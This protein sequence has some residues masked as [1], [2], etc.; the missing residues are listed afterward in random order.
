MSLTKRI[1]IEG[2]PAYAAVREQVA[3]QGRAHAAQF[4]VR[5]PTRRANRLP[6]RRWDPFWPSALQRAI[7]TLGHDSVWINDG[8]FVQTEEEREAVVER[9]SEIADAD[10]SR[11]RAAITRTGGSA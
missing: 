11:V 10:I 9:A 3:E 5:I 6:G 1:W 4:T 8:V 7:E 2:D